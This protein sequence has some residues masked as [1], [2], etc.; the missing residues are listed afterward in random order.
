LNRNTTLVVPVSMLIVAILGACALF[1]TAAPPTATNLP[2]I[3]PLPTFTP[4]LRAPTI[5]PLAPPT[6][7]R[8]LVSR[9][10]TSE[11]T[12]PSAT[13]TPTPRPATEKDIVDL[14]VPIREKYKLP[15]LGGTI[16][17]SK[18]LVAAGVTG[19]RKAGT[20][21]PVTV[22]DEW[23]LGSDTKAMTAVMIG[24]LVEQ[25]KLR[26]DMTLGEVFPDLAP[27]M[28]SSFRKVTFLHLLSHE[29]G[30]PMNLDW[31]QLSSKGTPREQREM[32]VK[33]G[34]SVPPLYT[35]G[36]QYQ[37]SNAGYVLAAAM[38]ERVTND[39]W[40]DLITR[41]LFQPLGM[42]N[43]G[44]GV[45][46]TPGQLDQPWPHLADGSPWTPNDGVED[47]PP[48]MAP[49]GEVHATMADWAKFIADQLNG[50]RGERAL[51]GTDIYQK[52][53]TPPFGGDYAL[54]WLVADRDWGGG[55]VYTHNGSNNL[56]YATVWLAPQRDFA[57]LAVTNQGG[58]NAASATDDAVAAM[59]GY[60]TRR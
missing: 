53:H 22:N 37:Y 42:K 27:T 18:G 10:A 36:T 20:N 15:S 4:T 48:V 29:A 31:F 19:I 16:V 8:T 40:E 23:H 3:P 51:L 55:T 47:N 43:A 50:S 28:N 39:S 56:N 1:P 25:G 9:T 33:V 14:L 7:G 49:A 11:P 38:A 58:D 12:V 44:F 2:T 34:T 60:Y 57:F 21:V 13:R 6:P 24:S 54:G 35:P 5:R 46:G 41:L 26:W 52:L 30:L 32:A 17:T 45:A 59:I